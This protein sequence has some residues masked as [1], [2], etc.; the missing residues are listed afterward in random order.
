MNVDYI[1]NLDINKPSFPSIA[2]DLAVMLIEARDLTAFTDGFSLVTNMRLIFTDDVNITPYDAIDLTSSLTAMVYQIS[3]RCRFILL[4][5]SF[6]RK[7]D[8]ATAALPSK[9]ILTGNLV[10]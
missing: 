1:N 9:L 8:T 10:H 3:A 4:Y 2:D 7:N 6:H 5:P